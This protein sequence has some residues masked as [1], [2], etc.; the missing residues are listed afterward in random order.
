MKKLNQSI[1]HLN[2]FSLYVFFF[3]RNKSSCMSREMRDQL[4]SLFI[5]NFSFW[6]LLCFFPIAYGSQFNPQRSSLIPTTQKSFWFLW[7][8]CIY[9][10]KFSFFYVLYNQRC[11][12]NTKRKKKNPVYDPFKHKQNVGKPQSRLIFVILYRFP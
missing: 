4:P 11:V 9:I 2:D 6:L 12:S 8:F 3:T 1:W 7:L 5:L 10:F